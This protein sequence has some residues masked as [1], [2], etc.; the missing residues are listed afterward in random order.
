MLTSRRPVKKSYDYRFYLSKEVIRN[1]KINVTTTEIKK[2][3][4]TVLIEGFEITFFI[5]TATQ[6]LMHSMASYWNNKN[7]I[8]NSKASRSG[9][10]LALFLPTRNLQRAVD[11]SV[12]AI[13]RFYES[14]TLNYT[15]RNEEIQDLRE[16]WTTCWHSFQQ[17]QREE[18]ARDLQ[19][20]NINITPHKNDY[21]FFYAAICS[22]KS[23]FIE[24]KQDKKIKF[25]LYFDSNLFIEKII[26]HWKSTDA[27][28]RFNDVSLLPTKVSTP[29][30]TFL[31]PINKAEEIIDRIH[32]V[33]T[34]LCQRENTKDNLYVELINCWNKSQLDKSILLS[35]VSH[36]IISIP[37]DDQ[38]TIIHFYTSAPSFAKFYH[39]AKTMQQE[40]LIKTLKPALPNP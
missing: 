1:A 16:T 21:D 11:M 17:E 23:T 35:E 28:L 5:P 40:A 37:K 13:K 38:L 4:P 32:Q 29:F 8:P 26:R 2:S 10:S 33:I 15:M 30:M 34:V 36:P 24:E 27:P 18:E 25:N 9:T 31:L 22:E 6:P 3:N 12:L 7:P 39:P 19:N 14:K 20:K